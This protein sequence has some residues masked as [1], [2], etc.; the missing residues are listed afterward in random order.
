MN[1]SIVS[2]SRSA[3]PPQ[4]GQVVKRQL[5]CSFRGLSPD[6]RHSTSSGNSTGSWFSGTATSP[7]C[8]QW[9]I[10]IGEPQYLCLDI[11]QSPSDN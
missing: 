5:G 9:M 10:G 11:N 6:G 4:V 7:Q 1:V 8:L 2:V 3:S